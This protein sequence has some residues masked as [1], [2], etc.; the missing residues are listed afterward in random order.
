MS[1]TMCRSCGQPLRVG[2]RVCTHCGTPITEV[3][4]PPDVITSPRPVTQPIE[5][6]TPVGKVI[7][8]K[9]KHLAVLT[10][11]VVVILLGAIAAGA[12][13]APEPKV[14]G[15]LVGQLPFGPE[16]G[17]K[18]FDNGAGKIKVPQG[19]LD[20]DQTI[21]VRRNPIRQRVSAASPTGAQLSFPPG[22]LVAYT[23]GPISL[24]FN[25]PITIILQLPATGQGGLV[26]VTTNGQIRFFQGTISG[27]TISIRLNSLDLSQS[28][29][30]VNP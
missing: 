25:R 20:S 15:E 16:G 27:Q 12:M 19:A 1:S 23:F 28:G 8:L 26:F 11:L 18:E 22:A 17:T 24:T 29:V 5:P 2:V 3:G 9:S 4:P 21:E 13:T 14:A 7:R 30:V 6:L 10:G